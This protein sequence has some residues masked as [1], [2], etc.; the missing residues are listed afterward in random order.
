[1]P[2]LLSLFTIPTHVAHR[3]EK[4]QWNESPTCSIGEMVVKLWQGGET[5]LETDGCSKLGGQLGLVDFRVG[6]KLVRYL[7]FCSRILPIRRS[8][9]ACR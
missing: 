1:L 9:M 8:F 3:L 5:Y 4:L 2:A 6:K 7:T